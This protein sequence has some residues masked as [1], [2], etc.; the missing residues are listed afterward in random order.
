MPEPISAQVAALIR[1]ANAASA[2]GNLAQAQRQAR[3]A[4]ARA[5]L[6]L[7]MPSQVAAHYTLATM[8]WSDD[9]AS[10]EEAREH[11][12]KALE[13]ALGHTEEY[14]MAVTLLARIEAG[15]GNLEQAKRLNEQLLEVYKRKNRKAGIADVLRS[16]GDL[17]LKSNELVAARQCF[18][19]SL[20]FYD[21][22][23]ED[24]LNEA[25]L[26]LSMG[27]LEFRE[28]DM[29]EARRHWERA[30]SIGTVHGF[31]QVVAMAQRGLSAVEA[32]TPDE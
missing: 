1:K 25:G 26:H 27:S 17:A 8:L 13:L 16:F 6:S 11:A 22:D 14:Y 12:A 5:K 15:L 18:R 23:V 10:V 4:V 20:A 3:A 2:T 31:F 9:T 30:H 28:G 21:A 24:P 19:E 7:H 32:Y 29:N